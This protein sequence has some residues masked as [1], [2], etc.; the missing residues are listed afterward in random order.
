MDTIA[1]LGA[2]EFIARDTLNL[3]VQFGQ[4]V[5]AAQQVFAARQPGEGLSRACLCGRE[6]CCRTN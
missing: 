3:P 6:A 5:A 1:M 4:A 2:L